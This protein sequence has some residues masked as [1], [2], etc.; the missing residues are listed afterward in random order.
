MPGNRVT[1]PV[2]GQ[3]GEQGYSIKS[4]SLVG[5]NL[6]LQST[7]GSTFDVGNVKGATG[8]AGASGS[9]LSDPNEPDIIV[10]NFISQGDDN[11]SGGVVVPYPF[12]GEGLNYTNAKTLSSNGLIKVYEGDSETDHVGIVQL[13]CEHDGSLNTGL[14]TLG[15]DTAN[16]VD[17]TSLNTLYVVLKTPNNEPKPTF[18]E[19]NTS[20]NYDIYVGFFS[21]GTA[22]PTDGI[23]F[24]RL[25]GAAWTPVCKT[26]ASTTTGTTTAYAN[27]TWYTLRIRKVSSTQVG[28]TVNG[29]TEVIISTNIP[30]G[31]LNCGIMVKNNTSNSSVRYLKLD[32]FSLKI[33]TSN[34]T[35]TNTI[36]GTANE[37][38]VTGPVSNIITVGLPDSIIVP[39]INTS[40]LNFNTSPATPTNTIGGLYWDINYNTMSLGLTA[41]TQLKIGQGLYKYARNITGSLIPKGKVVYVNGHHASTQLTIGLADASQELTSA[42]VIGVVAEDIANNTSG[43]V[44]TFG[45]LTGFPTNTAEIGAGNEGKALYLSA[46][47]PGDMRIGLPTQP[48]HG[49]RVGFLVQRSGSG[50]MFVNVQNY[51]ELEELSDVEITSIADNDILQWDN[52][53]LRWENRSLATAGIAASNHTHT[54]DD[55]SNVTVP[56]PIKNDTIYWDSTASLWKNSPVWLDPTNPTA[57]VIF[58]E[59][60]LNG[61]VETGESGL[62]GWNLANGTLTAVN[63]EVNHP[64]IAR[65]RCSGTANTVSWL[66]TANT[67]NA[68]TSQIHIDDLEEFCFIFK[69]VET[70]LDTYRTIGM[71]SNATNAAGQPDGIYLQKDIIG[72]PTAG[73]WNFVSQRNTTTRTSVTW[74]AQD[75]NW[76]KIIV[77]VTPSQIDFYADGATSPTATITTTIPTSVVLAP[78]LIL[79]PT[80]TSLVRRTDLDFFSYRSRN[81][82]R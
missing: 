48:L 39:T 46:I 50:A 17:F 52:T 22:P 53:D 5:D 34:A 16:I 9:D 12:D 51:Q 69:D 47:T 32:F 14:F 59:D 42:D 76:H 13:K 43:Y 27:N 78:F 80:G 68:T 64:G 54:L 71:L 2:K 81:I 29:G 75:T 49:V 28:F 6:V 33:G 24:R 44:Q 74:Q 7:S 8:P 26:G 40:Q 70:D 11:T 67:N 37:V 36:V 4:A 25:N 30:T 65:Y 66:S 19:R 63:S 55:L 1:Q 73:T 61:G 21:D 45:Y 35:T 79:T 72:L 57:P 58:T 23:Y 31:Y 15:R 20:T 3:K 18:G 38:E 10:D 82:N 60:F 62:F 56:S 41:N 77:K